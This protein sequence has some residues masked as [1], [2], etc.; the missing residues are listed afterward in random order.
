MR[1]LDR[2]PVESVH[3]EPVFV[4]VLGAGDVDGLL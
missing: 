4:L 2:P 3:W 1:E